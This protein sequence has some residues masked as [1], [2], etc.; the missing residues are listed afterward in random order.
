MYATKIMPST[1]V[2]IFIFCTAVKLSMYLKFSIKPFRLAHLSPS[3][4]TV[5]GNSSDDPDCDALSY[6]S[7]GEHRRN[8]SVIKRPS[9]YPRK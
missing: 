7:Q 4:E 5:S 3:W 6:E 2:G 9:I 8:T 1:L